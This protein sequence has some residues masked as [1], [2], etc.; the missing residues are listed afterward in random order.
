MPRRHTP[1][2]LA[3]AAAVLALLMACAPPAAA[4]RCKRVRKDLPAEELWF[5]HQPAPQLSLEQLPKSFD[6]NN[7]NGRSML[8]SVCCEAGAGKGMVGGGL[9][10]PAS[11]QLLPLRI[12]F[13]TGAAGCRFELLLNATCVCGNAG[14][15]RQHNRPRPEAVCWHPALQAP[16]WNQLLLLIH[17]LIWLSCL[18]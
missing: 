13:C 14:R 15:C 3:A 1:A 12:C 16:S 18:Y 6:W 17:S 8:V 11:L 5:N 4:S 10:P 2:P 9:Q 7:V